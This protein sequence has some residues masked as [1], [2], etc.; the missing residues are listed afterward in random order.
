M[1]TKHAIQVLEQ[2]AAALHMQAQALNKEG[3]YEEAKA[4]YAEMNT[5]DSEALQLTKQLGCPS[6]QDASAGAHAPGVAAQYIEG[7]STLHQPTSWDA[8]C[9]SSDRAK[10]ALSEIQ[11]RAW[12]LSLAVV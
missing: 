5:L 11:R 7:Y 6:C 10:P 2:R 1:D 3:K 9:S 8:A 12:V 4:T